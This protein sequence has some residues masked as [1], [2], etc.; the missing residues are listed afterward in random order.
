VRTAMRMQG[1]LMAEIF[2]KSLVLTPSA[3]SK[4]PAG[5]ITNLLA[6]DAWRVS[7]TCVVPMLHWG[8]WSA[9]MAF[10]VGLFALSRIIGVGADP[11]GLLGVCGVRSFWPVL[12]LSG[13]ILF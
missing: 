8:T 2:R 1:A 5:Q 12:W 10:G 7:D 9:L 4:Y 3:R 6:V 11:F 13:E